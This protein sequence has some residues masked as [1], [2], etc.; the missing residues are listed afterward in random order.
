MP[1]RKNG[2]GQIYGL[3]FVDN[4]TKCVFNGSDLGKDYSAAA[5]Q[6]RLAANEGKIV[7]QAEDKQKEKSGFAMAAQP[8]RQTP[9][10]K[11]EITH[12]GEKLLD[13]LLWAKEPYDTIPS[14]LLHKKRKKKKRRNPNS[15]S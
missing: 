12:Y 13:A 6:S 9:G 3:T 1:A 10:K 2:N 5:V 7:Q 15:S 8:V 14:H 4:Q 11:E